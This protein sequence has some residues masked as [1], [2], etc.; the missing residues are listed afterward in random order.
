MK[1]LAFS[2]INLNSFSSLSRN[3]KP[4]V[5]ELWRALRTLCQG[6]QFVWMRFMKHFKAQTNAVL[7]LLTARLN[8][9]HRF[10]LLKIDSTA[11]IL[12]KVLDKILAS[13]F[14]H[15]SIT[16]LSSL[17]C[18]VWFLLKSTWKTWK[19]KKTVLIQRR[20][21]KQTR[22]MFLSKKQSSMTSLEQGVRV[23]LSYLMKIW[24]AASE[25]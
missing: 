5:R 8:N 4:C 21:P 10:F 7:N 25:K 1:V 3:L 24:K 13:D 11:R 22:K 19:W 9:K 18:W 17:H 12:S 15:L 23:C 14:Y 16:D 6:N 20:K 2:L